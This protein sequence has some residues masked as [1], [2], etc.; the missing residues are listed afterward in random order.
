MGSSGKPPV[1]TLKS[2]QSIKKSKEDT[3]AVIYDIVL[4]K[5]VE[6]ILDITRQ[7]NETHLIFE[8]PKVIIGHP[9]YDIK[10]CAKYIEKKLIDKGYITKRLDSLFLYIDWSGNSSNGQSKSSSNF[11]DFKFKKSLHI[12]SPEKLKEK[13]RDLL[14]KYPDT[15]KVVF[16]YTD[17]DKLKKKKSKKK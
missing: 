1:P 14:K 7:T 3:K 13:T 8:L 5:C 17:E 9:T 6:K 16:V 11:I 10:E 2:L 12:K 15:S 4:G